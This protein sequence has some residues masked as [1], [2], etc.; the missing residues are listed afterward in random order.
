MA[1]N[2]FTQFFKALK[3]G[4]KE[5][6][7]PFDD[8]C[9]ES[10]TGDCSLCDGAVSGTF[11]NEEYTAVGGETDVVWTGPLPASKSAIWLYVGG[12]K[13]ASSQYTLSSNTT[14]LDSPLAVG[15][16]VEIHFAG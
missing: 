7:I 3:K 10:Y 12:Q 16:L 11:G 14:T 6:E 13:I 8:P 15:Q 9:D 5:L 2:N 4:L 1:I